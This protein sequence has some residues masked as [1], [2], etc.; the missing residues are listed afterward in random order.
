M[1][2]EPGTHETTAT[3]AGPLEAA[4]RLLAGRLAPEHTPETAE[5]TGNVIA[6]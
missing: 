2:I 6:R 4:V 5:V 1:S 3:Y